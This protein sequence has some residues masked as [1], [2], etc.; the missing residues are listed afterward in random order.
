M[1]ATMNNLELTRGFEALQATVN[2]IGNRLATAIPEMERNI[3]TSSTDIKMMYDAIRN[4]FQPMLDSFNPLQVTVSKEAEKL[5]EL[6]TN[7]HDKFNTVQA[8]TKKML[9]S[10]ENQL[11]TFNKS[12]S[13][14]RSRVKSTCKQGW[15]YMTKLMLSNPKLIS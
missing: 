13:S 12:S 15:Q 10:L 9:E 8:D 3:A 4:D 7:T 6:E 1:A 2:D 11:G 14:M 5:Q